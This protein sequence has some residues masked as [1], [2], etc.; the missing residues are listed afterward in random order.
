MYSRRREKITEVLVQLEV[1]GHVVEKVQKQQ[2]E[3]KGNRC[4]GAGTSEVLKI[5]ANE[6]NRVSRALC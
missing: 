3:R 6:E 1:S 2:A 5:E 4:F